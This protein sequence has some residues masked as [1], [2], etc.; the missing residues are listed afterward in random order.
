MILDLQSTEIFLLFINLLIYKSC[1]V[2]SSIRYL[3]D[4]IEYQSRGAYFRA[5]QAPGAVFVVV[6]CLI[7]VRLTEPLQPTFR[8]EQY[9]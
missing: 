2:I 5:Y 4:N 7:D 9:M 6:S 8:Q 1:I 3:K